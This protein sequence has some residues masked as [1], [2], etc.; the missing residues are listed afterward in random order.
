MKILIAEPDRISRDFLK[1]TLE[2]LR[3]EVT[4]C[5]SGEEAWQAYQTGD[6]GIVISDWAMAEMDG[7]EL[8]RRIRNQNRPAYCYFIVVTSRKSKADSLVSMDAGADDYITKPLDAEEIEARLRVAERILV[9]QKL[10][11][12]V[13]VPRHLKPSTNSYAS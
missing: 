9:L 13:E 3:Y 1:R 7:L 4:P 8:C 5:E 12:V 10:T 6:F 11:R 2:C